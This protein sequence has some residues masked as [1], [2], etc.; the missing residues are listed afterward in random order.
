MTESKKENERQDS[1]Q[2]KLSWQAP[3][4]AARYRR[5]RQ[6]E[7]FGPRFHREGKIISTWLADLPK[8]ALVLDAPCGTG[9]LMPLIT[10]LGLR[11]MGADISSAMML[12]AKKD[13]TDLP[14]GANSAIGFAR[15]DVGALPFPDGSFDAVVLWRFLHHVPNSATRIGILQEAARVSR[16]RVILSFHH[17]LSV[18]Y[19]FN[20]IKRTF[21]GRKQGGRGVTHWQL[22][23]EA[24]QC[25]LEVAEFGSYRRVGSINWFARLQKTP[26]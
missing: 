1:Y 11:Y 8:G 22:R 7:N 12:E 25:G 21:F 5:S 10:G 17:P 16:G 2:A 9:R 3:A 14:A 23:R 4:N 13:V 19:A 24:A 6:P 18:T 20:V 15:A 26:R